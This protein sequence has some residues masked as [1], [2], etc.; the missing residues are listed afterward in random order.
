MYKLLNSGDSVL[1]LS[2]N[3]FIPLDE[4]SNCDYQ[5]YQAWLAAGNTPEPAQTD[6]EILAAL[7]AV[8]QATITS[9]L[10]ELD[11][12]IPRGLEDT[13]AILGIDTT[14]LPA[15]QQ[16]RL[17]LKTALRTA[18]N[19]VEAATTVSEVESIVIPTEPT[20]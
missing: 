11:S 3:T 6:V 20:V 18:Y 1:R 4:G 9:K 12:F 5:E 2:D 7:K 10:S 17:K 19:A 15:V 8:K 16:S 14:K 13:W